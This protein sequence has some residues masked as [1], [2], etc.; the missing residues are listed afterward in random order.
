MAWVKRITNELRQLQ[1]G[2]NEFKIGST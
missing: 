1:N 2:T